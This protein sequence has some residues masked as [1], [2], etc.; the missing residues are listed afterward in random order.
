MFNKLRNN[1]SDN[2]P[3]EAYVR[4]SRSFDALANQAYLDF[5]QENPLK[6]VD[7]YTLD[8]FLQNTYVSKQVIS[9]SQKLNISENELKA[10]CKWFEKSDVPSDTMK[11]FRDYLSLKAGS[12]SVPTEAVVTES[13]NR[14]RQSM[15]TTKSI[16][17]WGTAALWLAACANVMFST[18]DNGVNLES[19]NKYEQVESAEQYAERIQGFIDISTLLSDADNIM[20]LH[21]DGTMTIEEVRSLQDVMM[22]CS[23]ALDYTDMTQE[24]PESCSNALN[25]FS[26]KID[27]GNINKTLSN[28]QAW[29]QWFNTNIKIKMIQEYQDLRNMYQTKLDNT[30]DDNPSKK[31][32]YTLLLLSILAGLAFAI[33]VAKSRS[34]DQ[35][36]ELSDLWSTLRTKINALIG[37]EVSSDAT[38]FTEPKVQSHID[39]LPEVKEEVSRKYVW[40]G[41]DLS[42]EAKIAAAKKALEN[43]TIVKW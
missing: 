24:V 37:K 5:I 23:N 22:D 1:Q 12:L 25:M 41:V 17:V 16:L 13:K 38:E 14:T 40:E 32:K 6:D 35:S 8:K 27:D 34:R 21:T 43:P 30:P 31:L 28:L 29:P 11:D 3:Q 26:S 18:P 4:V 2:I 7:L 9:Q 33:A 19:D 42:P 15:V 10:I 39:T 20:V 36:R